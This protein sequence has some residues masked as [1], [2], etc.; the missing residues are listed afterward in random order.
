MTYPFAA[1][2]GQDEMKLA[3][4]LCAIDPQI[5]GVLLSGSRGAAKSTAARALA[6]LLPPVQVH[7]GCPF[8]CGPEE[9]CNSCERGPLRSEPTP[10]AELPLGATEDRLV[11]TLDLARALRSGETCLEP[12]LLARAHRG[13]LYVDEVNLLPDHLVDLLLDAAA[14]GWNCVEREGVSVRH[15]ARFV[16]VGTMNPD[17]GELRPQLLDRFGLCVRVQDLHEPAERA[18]AAR[19]AIEYGRAREAFLLTWD[20]LERALRERIAAARRALVH[21]DLSD[22]LA[23]AISERCAKER[24][25]GLRADLALARSAMALA[26]WEGRAHVREADV[27]RVAEL[28]LAHRRGAQEPDSPPHGPSD[29]PRPPAPRPGS[30]ADALTPFDVRKPLPA[31][32]PAPPPTRGSSAARERAGTRARALAPRP[33]GGRVR[34]RGDEAAPLALAATLRSAARRAP[35]TLPASVALDD[36]RVRTPRAQPSRLYVFLLDASRSMGA[37]RRMEL[38]KGALLGLLADAERRRDEVALVGFRG[39]HATLLLPP[40]R[41]VRR[42]REAVTSLAVGGR[43]PLAHAVA[44]AHQL[45]ERAR[46][47]D[48]LRSTCAVLVSDGRPTQGIGA[49]SPLRSAER[50]LERLRRAGVDLVLVDTEAGPPHIGRMPAWAARFGAPLLDLDALSAAALR[51]ESRHG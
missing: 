17:E 23:A 11:G 5:G 6:H 9:P 47:L 10:F 36:L 33:S 1:V 32:L 44:L 48:A 21:V 43:T 24:A 34:A 18:E 14:S 51:R 16:L 29:P 30:G 49:S 42:A 40:T 20:A 15:P 25:Q 38:T 8:R 2:L 7:A 27:E 19:R 3:L 35:G 28:A 37:R 41:S 39:A 26:A 50:E 46:R 4:V 22:D 31:R 13:V 45:A 12:G